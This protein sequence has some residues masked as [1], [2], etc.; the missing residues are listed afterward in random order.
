MEDICTLIKDS[1]LG[2]SDDDITKDKSGDVLYF[3]LLSSNPKK[4]PKPTTNVSE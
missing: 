1:F 4:R 2:C 3:F